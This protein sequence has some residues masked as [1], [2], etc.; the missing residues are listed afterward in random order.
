[1]GK[2]HLQKVLLTGASG[3]IGRNLIEKIKEDCHIYALARR[4]QQ[5]AGVS[6]HG[7]IRWIS[8]DITDRAGL[9]RVFKS[10]KEENGADFVIHLAAYYDFNYGPHPEYD[11]TNVDGTRLILEHSRGLGI[12]RFIFASS[13][14]AC[15]FPPPGQSVNENSPLDADFPYAAAKRRC[16]E[17]L[18]AFSP[19][20]PCVSIR[21]AAVYSDWCEY[22]PLYMLLNNWLSSSWLSRIIPGR[23][24]M[25]IPYIHI[26]C[27]IDA[28]ILLME[29]SHRLP[30]YDTYVVS[31]YSTGSLRELF[32]LST[33]L[34]SGKPKQPIYIPKILSIPGVHLRN[35]WGRL[36]GRRPFERPWMLKYVDLK[37]TA[38]SGYT[39]EALGWRPRAE[40]DLIHRM[41]ILIE[42]RRGDPVEWRRKN[43]AAMAKNGREEADPASHQLPEELALFG[44]NRKKQQE[45]HASESCQ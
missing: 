21:L 41:P 37:L 1:M 33:R 11:R 13:L 29:R 43:M 42:N 36:T 9:A 44:G 45:R 10:I 3:F 6:P 39:R 14:A 30:Q 2:R 19:S 31:P 40:L 28:I 24:E 35:H 23:G 27:V 20:M 8:V 18:R 16:E 25:A 7:N 15:T 5:E 12:R 26:Q 32:E 34:Y 4:T 38:D 17:M 22:P